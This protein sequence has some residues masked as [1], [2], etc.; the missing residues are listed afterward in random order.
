MKKSKLC[1]TFKNFECVLTKKM[2]VTIFKKYYLEQTFIYIVDI[3]TSVGY[4]R[5][6]NKK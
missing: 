1:P 2:Y 3:K 5:V 4:T 6:L